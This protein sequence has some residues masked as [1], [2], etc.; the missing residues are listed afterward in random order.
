M[1]FTGLPALL[2]LLG[3]ELDRLLAG[4]LLGPEDPRTA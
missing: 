3:R 2:A 4:E 1:G